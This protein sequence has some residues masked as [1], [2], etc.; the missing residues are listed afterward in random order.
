MV[1]PAEMFTVFLVMLGPLKILGPFAQR[2]RGVDDA[3]TRQIAWWT[4]IV[5][6][7]A[8]IAGGLLGSRVLVNWHV[9]LPALTLTAGIVFFLVAL[10]QLLEQ[11]EPSHALAPEALPPSPIAA[12]CRLVFPT[13]LTPY[14][15]AAVIAL[16][17]SSGDAVRTMT[18][19][20]V[21]VGVMVLNLLAM[22]FAKRILVG[23]TVMV[24]QVLG[25]VLAVLQV[26]LSVQI[27]LTGLRSL[28]V[29][30]SQ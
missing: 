11:Y 30:A 13:V 26:A 14:G 2:T 9:S 19:L 28:G 7:L 25:A 20:L 3:T 5:A 6:T 29:L 1:G 10:S 21:L 18:I 27:I 4:F 24:L 8:A 12:A 23:L 16:L 22:S 17:A 15:I